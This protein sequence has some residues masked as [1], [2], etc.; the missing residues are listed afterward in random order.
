MIAVRAMAVEL[1]TTAKSTNQTSVELDADAAKHLLRHAG[2][3]LQKRAHA[4]NVLEA[5]RAPERGN[6]KLLN[7]LGSSRQGRHALMRA[8]HAHL[9][10]ANSAY[11]L[12]AMLAADL[13]NMRP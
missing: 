2:R 1:A 7:A 12:A 4:A 11:A 6:T 3:V 5:R 10:V 8:G 9:A 13:V